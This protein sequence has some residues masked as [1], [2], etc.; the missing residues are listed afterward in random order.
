MP[1]RILAALAAVLAI[2]VATPARLG[3]EPTTSTT[4]A[5]TSTTLPDFENAPKD[6][7]PNPLS[8][9]PRRPGARYDDVELR[10]AAGLWIAASRMRLIR[11]AIAPHDS[12]PAGSQPTD[13]DIYRRF[14]F[15]D[16]YAPWSTDTAGDLL[17]VV[18]HVK[19]TVFPAALTCAATVPG[20]GTVLLPYAPPTPHR[21]LGTTTTEEPRFDLQPSYAEFDLPIG[22]RRGRVYI[23]CRN[24]IF[25][26]GDRGT[27]AV[28]GLLDDDN[29]AVWGID[30]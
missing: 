15:V 1:R 10:P 16:G 29:R 24:T 7:P 18:V 4:T 21:A 12:L 2:L 17:H 28:V 23:T 14:D 6:T 19:P 3:G 11:W 22:T 20:D 8:L 25:P 5:T 27:D 13:V 9:Y 26:P 30:V